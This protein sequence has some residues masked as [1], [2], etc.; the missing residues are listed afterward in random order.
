MPYAEGRIYNDADAHVMEPPNWLDNYADARTRALLKPID[1]ARASKM[2][3]DA[4][5]G[6]FDAKH[7]EQVDI[8]KNLMFIKGWAALG[9]F[10]PAERTRALNL[11]GFNRQ[12]VFISVALTQFWGAFNQLQV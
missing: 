2:A 6:K 9:A 5:K 12:L 8:E 10:D 3:E 11:L 4:L 1:F 7:W